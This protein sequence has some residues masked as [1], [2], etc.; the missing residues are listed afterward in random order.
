MFKD[1]DLTGKIIGIAIK[2][3]KDIGLAFRKKFITKQ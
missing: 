3:H 1:E 2:I